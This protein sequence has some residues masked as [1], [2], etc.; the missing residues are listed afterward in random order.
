MTNELTCDVL[1]VGGGPGGYPAAIRAGQHGL[2][3]IL[4]E[5]D[6]LGGTCLIRGCLPSKAVIHAAET[7]EQASRL[8]KTPKMGISL[9]AAPHLS[10]P[11]LRNWKEGIV[12]KLSGGVGGL[13]KAAGVTTI[14]GWATFSNAKTCTVETE[15]GPKTIR[16]ENVVLATGS[17]ETELPH[18]KYDGD[19]IL[20]SRHVLDLDELP[21]SVAIVGAGYIGME[22]GI[23]LSKLGSKVT[24]IEAG[25]KVL[26]GFD[27]ELIKP[28]T[29]ALKAHGIQVLTNA[30]AS[31]VDVTEDSAVLSYDTENGSDQIS[32][33]KVIVTVGRKPVLEG[34][35]FE[36]MGIDLDGKFIKIDN[37]CRTS[38]S[39]VYA[40]GDVTGEPMLAHR[41][42]AQGE[43]VA[44]ILAGQKRVFDPT[45]IPAVCFTDPE[46]VSVGLTPDEAEAAGENIIVGRFPF[47]ASGRALSMNAADTKGFVRIT[48][49]KSDHVILGVHAVG[50][51]VSELSSEFVLAME[52][53]AVLEDLSH[54]IHVHPTLSEATAEAAM[55]ALGHPIHIAAPK[56]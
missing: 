2:K 43:C 3:T 32:V 42:T 33:E 18:L 5:A 9:S 31:G 39:G 25:P 8:A 34:W 41:A 20:S 7:F 19:K 52:M 21:S 15:D 53:G 28:V 49:R 38:M 45:V 24:F 44:D 23:A 17:T 22:L 48:T 55:M 36:S 10:M 1:V 26:P 50:A 14:K 40:I 35:G 51:H 46:L 30:K 47:A 27:R 29:D 54:T 12:D 11:D 37:Q 16:A 56:R 6:R 4:V 13:L